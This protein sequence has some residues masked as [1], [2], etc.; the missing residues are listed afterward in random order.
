[1][2]SFICYIRNEYFEMTAK[3]YPKLTSNINYQSNC[4]L[5]YFKEL[6]DVLKE[7]KEILIKEEI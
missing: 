3:D 2:K 5:N 4:F 6:K 1:M 7:I